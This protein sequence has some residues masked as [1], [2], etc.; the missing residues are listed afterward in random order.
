[1]FLDGKG[2][3]SKKVR[4]REITIT[5]SA[6]HSIKLFVINNVGVWVYPFAIHE[7]LVGWLESMISLKQ[8]IYQSNYFM[9]QNPELQHTNVA[10][11]AALS[12]NE[13]GR[14][15]VQNIYKYT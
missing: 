1:M 8:T 3:P 6:K 10:E 5:N 7:V 15:F 14:C 4:L 11:L 2:D 12:R 13:G 9:R